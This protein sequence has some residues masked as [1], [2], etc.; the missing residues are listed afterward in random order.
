MVN[1]NKVLSFC[2]ALR[3]MLKIKKVFFGFFCLQNYHHF[4]LDFH[5][6]DQQGQ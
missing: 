4:K 6:V 1:E 3:Y 5:K 2:E